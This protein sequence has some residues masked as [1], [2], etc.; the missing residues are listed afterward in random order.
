MVSDTYGEL[1]W[2]E[3]QQGE[4]ER[5][6]A[7]AKPAHDEGGGAGPCLQQCL[8]LLY[9]VSCSYIKANATLH[10]FTC[11]RAL[12]ALY[13]SCKEWCWIR[14][15]GR[16]R[17]YSLHLGKGLGWDRAFGSLKCWTDT[18]FSLWSGKE[19]NRNDANAKKVPH[20]RGS[21][22]LSAYSSQISALMTLL[23]RVPR[24]WWGWLPVPYGGLFQSTKLHWSLVLK[25]HHYLPDRCFMPLAFE[26]QID[27]M[28][29]IKWSETIANQLESTDLTEKENAAQPS[30][31]YTSK[32]YYL[33]SWH[34]D[35]QQMWGGKTK[36]YA[37][38]SLVDQSGDNDGSVMVWGGK[39]KCFDY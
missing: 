34:D 2:Q 10:W 32:H 24:D 15:P 4:E 9:G 29:P 8:S 28:A 11:R 16:C 19:N 5:M 37:G 30:F 25:K 36:E 20:L 3:R 26:V 17:C 21:F 23:H 39:V 38:R 13:F 33:F 27:L 12:P 6:G 22:P 31:T 7:K 14:C 35:I 18:L 1:T